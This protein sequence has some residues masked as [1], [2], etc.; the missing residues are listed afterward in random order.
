MSRTIV[1]PVVL[2]IPRTGVAIDKEADINVSK[3]VVTDVGD[4]VPVDHL[5]PA[6]D[7]AAAG[8]DHAGHLERSDLV[9]DVDVLVAGGL[10]RDRLL[11][12]A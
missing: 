1:L 4:L 8:A 6:G 12:V 2:A 3:E 7:R 5:G 9:P 11:P 10:H